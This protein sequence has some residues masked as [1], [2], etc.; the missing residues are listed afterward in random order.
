MSTDAPS[1]DDFFAICRFGEHREFVQ[2]C[3]EAQSQAQRTG[4]KTQFWWRGYRGTV[5]A[6]LPPI[7]VPGMELRLVNALHK[8]PMK[9]TAETMVIKIKYIYYINLKFYLHSTCEGG[10]QTA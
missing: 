4:Q 7:T 10:T 8:I 6:N 9:S 5:F 3:L 2:I 1:L